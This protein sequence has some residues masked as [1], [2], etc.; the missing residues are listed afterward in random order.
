[1]KEESHNFIE[2]QN[3]ANAIYSLYESLPLNGK[4]QNQEFTVLAAIVAQCRSSQNFKIISL[5][6]GTKC[7]GR[8][9]ASTD[10]NGCLLSDSHGEVLA[11]RGFTYYLLKETLCISTSDKSELDQD[12][13]L[14]DIN[15]SING[16]FQIKSNVSISLFIS[17]NPCGD[18]SIYERNS[19]NIL[20]TGAKICDDSWR[21]EEI[22]ELGLVRTKSGRSTIE[23]KFRT[24]SMSCSDKICRWNAISLLGSIASNI[25]ESVH[26][27]TIIVGRDLLASKEVQLLSLQRSLV[28]RIDKYKDSTKARIEIVDFECFRSGKCNMEYN[29]SLESKANN[30]KLIPSGININWILNATGESNKH[31]DFNKKNLKHC[32]NGSLE[33]TLSQ[34]GCLQGCIKKNIGNR[35]FSSRLCK[36]S[37]ANLSIDVLRN[38]NTIVSV[39]DKI[40]YISLKTANTSYMDLKRRFLNEKPFDKWFCDEIQDFQLLN[41]EIISYQNSCKRIKLTA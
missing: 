21:R 14:L 32:S 6:T 39:N 27:D 11:K 18:S 4:T 36:S 12:D 3:I 20:F 10:I 9:L 29:K 30:V 41:E 13:F 8:E 23:E 25:I 2:S 40:S 17:D 7:I 33:V 22:Q 5:A 16:K 15:P 37:I 24:T 34:T 1:M 26:L 19:G 28:D 35:K 38:L 31:D